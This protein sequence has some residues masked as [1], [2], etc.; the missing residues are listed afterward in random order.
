MQVKD[1]AIEQK[2]ISISINHQIDQLIAKIVDRLIQQFEPES[3]FLFGS[4]VWGTPHADSDLDLLIIVPHSN[5]TPSKRSTV[6]YRCLRDI[7]YPL[8]IL[9]RTRQEIDKFQ[10]FP[11]SLEHQII[12]KGKCIYG[13]SK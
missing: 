9:V 4:Y 3:I 13:C 8:D 5:L 7:R 12:S 11:M 1:L 6:A 2:Q 10:Q